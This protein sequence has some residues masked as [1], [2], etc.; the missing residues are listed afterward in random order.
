[1]GDCLMRRFMIAAGL[2]L[3]VPLVP[4][5]ANDTAPSAAAP[6][7]RGAPASRADLM[8][9]A[10][11]MAPRE[12]MVRNELDGFNRQFPI[13]LRKQEGFAELETEF[14][15]L[16]PELVVEMKAPFERYMH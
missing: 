4:A 14:P 3:A 1:M 2:L 10:E 16:I 6:A 5:A 11:A 15:G 13:E 8:A 9:L 12:V 7:T